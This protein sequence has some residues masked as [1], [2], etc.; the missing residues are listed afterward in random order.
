MNE[1]PE[2]DELVQVGLFNILEERDVQ[3]RV[4]PSVSIWIS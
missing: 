3:I 2:L 4:I 1:L